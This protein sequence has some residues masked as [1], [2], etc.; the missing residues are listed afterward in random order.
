MIHTLRLLT[1][2]ENLWQ[3]E[4]FP[5][6]G[7]FPLYKSCWPEATGVGGGDGVTKT[8]EVLTCHKTILKTAQSA[9]VTETQDG[10][11]TEPDWELRMYLQV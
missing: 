4:L 11:M 10:E 6:Y 9:R 2:K 5:A 1:F 3:K 7:R 8:R